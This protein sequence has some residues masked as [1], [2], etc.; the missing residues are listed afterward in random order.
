MFFLKKKRALLVQLLIFV[1]TFIFFMKIFPLI[2]YDGD[3]WYFQG[4]M[5]NPWPMW[6][7]FNPS[8]VLP[9]VLEPLSGYFGAF[10]IYPLTHNY[11]AS[12]S[13]S[14]VLIITIA[15]T[16]LM[17]L[18]YRYIKIKFEVSKSKAL[19]L[20]LLFFISFFLI[21]KK[22][23]EPSY[24]GFWCQDLN[25]YFNYL[26]PGCLNAGLLLYFETVN[27]KYYVL[28]DNRNNYCQIGILIILIYFAMFSS[29]QLNVLFGGYSLIKIVKNFVLHKNLNIAKRLSTKWP[30]VLS[31]VFWGTSLLFD[32]NGG[33]ANRVSNSKLKLNLFQNIKN[34]FSQYQIMIHQTNKI[35]LIICLVLVCYGLFTS[36]KNRNEKK[37]N[38]S[39]LVIFLT[40]IITICFYTILYTKAPVTY[41]SRPDAMWGATFLGLFLAVQGF[42]FLLKKIEPLAILVPFLALFMAIISFN[43]NNGYILKDNSDAFTSYK[44]DNYV[45]NRIVNAEHHGKSV[46]KVKV[47]KENNVANWP[48]PL[49]QAQWMQNT[50]YSHGLIRHRIKVIF[51]PNKKQNKII[52]SQGKSEPF[53]DLEVHQ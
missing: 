38:L 15:I 10:V 34:V 51:V 33:R 4:A 41:A 11:V 14:S 20:E 32:F 48:H 18:I 46:V 7:V 21:F 13:F 36:I 6:G 40:T 50:L 30:F 39:Y 19:L 26:I 43:F 28:K 42:T 24:F 22:N 52:Y 53:T 35:F 27:E 17:A 5:R 49:N 37:E 44:Y 45:I 29:I 2:P 1:F 25:C 23:N 9:E 3:D 47:P 8:K 16:L 31:V 12:L